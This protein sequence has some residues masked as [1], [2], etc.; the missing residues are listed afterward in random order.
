MSTKKQNTKSNRDLNPANA[1]II[2]GW[3]ENDE[4][5][6]LQP[7]LGTDGKPDETRVKALGQVLRSSSPEKLR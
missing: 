3:N 2:Y 7:T 5:G 6:W 4:G 1:V